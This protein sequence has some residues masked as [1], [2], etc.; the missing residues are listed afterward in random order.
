MGWAASSIIH[1]QKNKSE[2][3]AERELATTE[4][5]GP[6]LQDY[7]HRHKN[8]QAVHLQ[9]TLYPTWDSELRG[10]GKII[11]VPMDHGVQ[12][13]IARATSVQQACPVVG[14]KEGESR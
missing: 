2:G 8:G 7:E 1:T 4:D 9:G 3:F 13:R 10:F 6:T 11:T 14:G 5:E 12:G